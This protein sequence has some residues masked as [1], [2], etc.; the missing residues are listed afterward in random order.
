MNKD[1]PLWIEK[2]LGFR[3]K[4]SIRGF[5]NIQLINQKGAEA[6]FC[7]WETLSYDYQMHAPSSLSLIKLQG[8]W[9]PLA[10]IF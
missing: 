9:A 8:R 7:V 5:H 2:L 3:T 6:G 4:A 10:I 1:I